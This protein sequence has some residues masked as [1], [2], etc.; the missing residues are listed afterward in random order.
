MD[1]S[2]VST[3][4]GR[5]GNRTEIFVFAT[6]K[7]STGHESLRAEK[8][9]A[10]HNIKCLSHIIREVLT[11]RSQ[12]DTSKSVLL[13]TRLATLVHISGSSKSPADPS[14]TLAHPA[15]NNLYFPAI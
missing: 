15:Y 12:G 7:A 4:L 3:R 10:T 14:T 9:C 5:K 6:S 11:F 1:V 13:R 8:K 2:D